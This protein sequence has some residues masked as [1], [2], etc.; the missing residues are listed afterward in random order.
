MTF[1][2]EG[3]ALQLSLSL[4][5]FQLQSVIFPHLLSI[6]H[7][8]YS[9]VPYHK[10]ST[11]SQCPQ[12]LHGGSAQLC[13]LGSSNCLSPKTFSLH[14]ATSSYG[15]T[16][17]LASPVVALNLKPLDKPQDLFFRLT[18]LATST[19]VVL[20]PHCNVSST[21]PAT[22]YQSSNLFFPFISFL[23]QLRFYHSFEFLIYL[24]PWIFDAFS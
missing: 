20:W 6:W 21:G 5:S 10:F 24:A 9:L 22:F 2:S 7:L 11:T 16:L 19:L 13:G 12:C 14:W 1:A 4:A 23:I 8:A 17:D 18:C 15:H 3:G